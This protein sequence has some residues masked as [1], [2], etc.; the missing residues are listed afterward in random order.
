MAL[1]AAV[2]WLLGHIAGLVLH[3]LVLGY[4]KG[5]TGYGVHLVVVGS[6]ALL[7]GVAVIHLESALEWDSHRRSSFAAGLPAVV[8]RRTDAE[9]EEAK[10]IAA[11]M[12]GEKYTVGVLE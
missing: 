10:H 11:A 5:W 2:G 6:R 12:E 3:A 8:E 9:W 1:C 7:L 4:M